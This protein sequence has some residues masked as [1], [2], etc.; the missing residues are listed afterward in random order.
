MNRS[1]MFVYVTAI[2]AL[3]IGAATAQT[4]SKAPEVDYT[5]GGTITVDAAVQAQE[6]LKA[7]KTVV[8]KAEE[9]KLVAEAKVTQARADLDR[10]RAGLTRLRDAALELNT[11]VT[12][13]EEADE[14]LVEARKATVL[15]PGGEKGAIERLERENKEMREAAATKA[16][17]ARVALRSFLS[18]LNAETGSKIDTDVEPSS[19]SSALEDA[20]EA[21]TTTVGDLGRA[22]A[23]AAENVEKAETF[24]RGAK[25]ELSEAEHQLK[26][27]LPLVG[28]LEIS[29]HIA[30]LNT[31]VDRL[32][33]SVGA[34]RG[35]QVAASVAIA[36]LKE[37]VSGLR[38]DVQ[39][40]TTEVR[41]VSRLVEAQSAEIKKLTEQ[42]SSMKFPEDKAKEV[43]TL[44]NRMEAKMHGLATSAQTSAVTT[45]LRELKAKAETYRISTVAHCPVYQVAWSCPSGP[46]GYRWCHRWCR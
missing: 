21:M 22:L 33:T 38:T 3:T 44:L 29:R 2:V 14:A 45:L 19:A 25:A 20:T 23:T 31:K 34:I 17:D 37:E 30:E 8:G 18:A 43:V 26:D 46:Y 11:L 36:G 27:I 15:V 16:K 40:V 4:P 39:A 12:A 10:A 6:R 13:S 32:T 7:A 28:Q 1:L 42:I 24:L 35:E 5:A 41:N 9:D